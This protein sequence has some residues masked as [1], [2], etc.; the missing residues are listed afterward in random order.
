[1]ITITLTD[2]NKY[3]IRKSLISIKDFKITNTK[4]NNYST[5]YFVFKDLFDIFLDGD[6]FDE[7]VF[8]MKRK[9]SGNYSF[10]NNKLVNMSET[11]RDILSK[12]SSSYQQYNIHE[13]QYRHHIQE[14]FFTVEENIS[15]T[16]K[17]KP[18]NNLEY[19][20][21]IEFDN[22]SFVDF[23]EKIDNLS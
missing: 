21:V 5:Y 20:L 2:D 1:M 13:L 8:Q 4:Y 16:C 23:M 17:I 19:Y 6:V 3:E 10:V 22:N 9:Q 15:L 11:I 7:L 18:D 14:L 12:N